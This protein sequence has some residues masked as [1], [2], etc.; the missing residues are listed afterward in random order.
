MRYFIAGDSV[1]TTMIS[2]MR[3]R[4]SIDSWGAVPIPVEKI[5]NGNRG[6]DQR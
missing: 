3:F 2:V 4:V 1:E 5:K 6:G